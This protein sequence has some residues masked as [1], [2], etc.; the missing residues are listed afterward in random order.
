[1]TI[2]LFYLFGV[3]MGLCFDNIVSFLLLSTMIGAFYLIRKQVKKY[4]IVL[5]IVFTL[6]GIIVAILEN[7]K[8]NDLENVEVFSGHG[9]IVD[10]EKSTDY[11]NVYLLKDKKVYYLLY[12]PKSIDLKS[13]QSIY[14]EGEFSLPDKARNEYGFNYREY[15]K[16]RKIAG[17]IKTQKL[18][19]LEN[20]GNPR[21]KIIGLKSGLRKFFKKSFSDEAYGFINGIILADDSNIDDDVKSLF[22]DT[23]LLH[24][25]AVSGMHINIIENILKK[26]FEKLKIHKKISQAIII[27]ILIIYMIM[28]GSPVSCMRAVIMA[29]LDMVAFILERKPNFQNNIILSIFIICLINP[30]NIF[31]I[32][33]WLSYMGTI[34]IVCLSKVIYKKLIRKHNPPS[35]LKALALENI[36]VSISVLILIF[37][38]II[39]YFNSVSLITLIS[40]LVI[41]PFIEP[42][43]CLITISCIACVLHI[44]CFSILTNY[45]IKILYKSISLVS[46]INFLNIFVARPNIVF[47]LVY[48]AIILTLIFLGKIHFIRIYRFIHRYYKKFIIASLIVVVVG[49][50]IILIPKSYLE[51]DFVDVAQGDCSLL[52]TPKHQSILIDGGDNKD[53]DYGEKVILPLL[54]NKRVKKIDYMLISHFDSDHVGGLITI[55][56]KYKVRNVIIAKQPE[57]T[58]NF[59]LFLSI[60]NKKKIK[61]ILVKM[62]DRIDIEKNINMF[63]LW[64]D[65]NNCIE[66]NALNNNSIVCKLCFYST[67]ILF[68]G[69]IEE[70]AEK[71]I[72]NIF[73]MDLNS[74]IIKV[75]HHGSISSS[76]EI[77]LK[78]ISPK[79][80]LIGV[81][82]NNKFGHP[83]DEIVERYDNMRSQNISYRRD[84]GSCI[85]VGF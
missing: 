18:N 41:T 84:G 49:K 20:K 14:Y 71:R 75:P 81:G 25:L 16:Q 17:S 74:D 78:E 80:A 57:M 11:K 19:V 26:I 82:K 8:Y 7:N 56:E 66:E 77:F 10:F 68:T 67:S 6:L 24:I 55:L 60:A 51:F 4:L 83:N 33:L 13:G 43:I 47:V 9:V 69:D 34:G 65:E 63:I 62:G 36:S 21:Y 31:N 50:I 28:I 1:M 22:K 38:I 3:Y 5:A 15:L 79:I 2:M 45:C 32:G 73:K 64:P 39:Y 85:K 27:F 35:K 52:I 40:N 37:P 23:S 30:Y 70:E 53:Y 42:I 12:T 59:K 48:Y 54:I 58:D 46:K 76:T 29:I 44:S 61:I 72:S